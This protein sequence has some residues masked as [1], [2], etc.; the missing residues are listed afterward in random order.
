MNYPF[1]FKMPAFK[2]TCRN[3]TSAFPERV[4]ISMPNHLQSKGHVT[5]Q[6][7]RTGE[8]IQLERKAKDSHPSG[9]PALNT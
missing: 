5:A 1:R 7:I 2:N 8:S 3:C 4:H 6:Q 9:D